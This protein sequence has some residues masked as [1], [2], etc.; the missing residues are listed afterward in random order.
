MTTF[1]VGRCFSD[2]RHK[3]QL[4]GFGPSR[5]EDMV[6]PTF[7]VLPPSLQT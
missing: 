5:G 6:Q 4:V 3:V 1:E 2:P 7:R